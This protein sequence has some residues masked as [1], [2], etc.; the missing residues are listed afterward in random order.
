[1]AY[2]KPAGP[3]RKAYAIGRMEHAY[4]FNAFDV[5]VIDPEGDLTDPKNYKVVGVEIQGPLA[6]GYANREFKLAV[7]R[8]YMGGNRDGIE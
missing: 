7:A 6:F 8:T 5:Q 4:Q 2:K 1:M 3:T